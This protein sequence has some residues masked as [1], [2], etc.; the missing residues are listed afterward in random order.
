[1]SGGRATFAKAGGFTEAMLTRHLT[2]PPARVWA[3]LSEDAEL[4][5]WL[6]PG[7]LEP[8]VGGA[9]RLDFADSGTVINSAVSAYEVGRLIE[10][11]WSAPGEPTRPVRLELAPEGEGTR[12]VVTLR[13]PVGED[14]G[15]SAAGWDAHLQMLEAA[16]A[17][18][19]IAFPFETFKSSR[20]AY[21]ATLAS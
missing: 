14:A 4:P 20:E 18:A 15:R 17:G 13:T 5:L 21:R 6:A 7:R 19:P 2:Q 12:L 9:A 1:M 10:F 8:R 11:S 16:L 3:M